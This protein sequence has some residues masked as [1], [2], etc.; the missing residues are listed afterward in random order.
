MEDRRT[1]EAAG[2]YSTLLEINNAIIS[3]LTQDSLFH[4]ISEALR[5]VVP[6]DRALLYVAENDVLRTIAL[7]W[8]G[9][10]ADSPRAPN[11][12]DPRS[13]TPRP[14]VPPPRAPPP[15]PFVHRMAPPPV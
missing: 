8:R 6:F 2:P 15:P 14:P 9:V 4:A 7:E 1:P 5:K 10:V 3:N 12:G 11:A 13:P